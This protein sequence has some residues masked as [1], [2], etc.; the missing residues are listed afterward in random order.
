MPKAKLDIRAEKAAIKSVLGEYIAAVE[1]KDLRRY[2][3]VMDHNPGMVN[4]GT[5]ASERIVGWDLLKKAMNAQF[6]S[7]TKQRI[8]ATFTTVALAPNGRFAWATS[9]WLFRAKM[10]KQAIRLPV[11]SSWVLEKRGRRW[12]IVH[13]HK[14][15][16]TAS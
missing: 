4:F 13:F 9:M 12:V 2:G 5:D 15:I 1:R 6:A 14:S 10:G 3:G 16:G 11:R 7:L 8:S